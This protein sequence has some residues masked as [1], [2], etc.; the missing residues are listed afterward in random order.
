LPF[1]WR[2]TGTMRTPLSAEIAAERSVLLLSKTTI[3]ASG[4]LAL[5]SSMTTPIV[6]S[7]L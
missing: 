1:P 5:T 4:Q 7:S 3:S 6:G 2:L